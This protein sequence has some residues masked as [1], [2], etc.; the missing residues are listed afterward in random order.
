[1][2]S[3]AHISVVVPVFR[4][5]AYLGRCVDS[6]LGQT[7]R[8]FDLVLVDDG[9]PDRCGEICDAYANAD[10]RVHV[11]H[12]K[13]AGLS[14]ARNV[15]M[16]WAFQN[17]TSE[18]LFFVDSD[19]WIDARTL[20]TLYDAAACNKASIAAIPPQYVVAQERPCE[21]VAPVVASSEDFWCQDWMTATTAWG[22]LYRKELF[23]LHHFL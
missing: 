11:I 14:A 23:P 20:E 5:E 6:I 10:G 3:N 2:R 15:G 4:V 9:S 19:D 13:N 22:K 1:M 17:S 18:W 8:D 16:E 21:I 12:Q 7:L